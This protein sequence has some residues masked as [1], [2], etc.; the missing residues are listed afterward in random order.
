[1]WYYSMNN[2]PAGPVDGDTIRSLLQSGQI[3]ANTLVWQEGMAD[4]KRLGETAFAAPVPPPQSV[5]QYA[6]PTTQAPM[7]SN[8][9][10]AVA[11]GT[12]PPFVSPVKLSNIKTFYFLWLALFAVGTLSTLFF[13]FANQYSDAYTTLACIVSFFGIAAAV[14]IYIQVYNFWKILQDGYAKITP[15]KAVGFLFIPLF[16]LYWAF[17]AFFG[18]SNEFNTFIDRHFP[19]ISGRDVRRSTPIISMVYCV[20]FILNFFLSMANYVSSMA[21]ESSF[22]AG[23]STMTIVVAVFTVLWAVM[24]VL[25]FTDYYQTAKSILEN[26]R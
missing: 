16:N 11:A 7:Y 10:P 5:Q 24:T 8:Y 17:Q 15:G 21:G 6:Q 13:M 4:W 2:Q 1:M 23:D 25:A 18:L 22:Y 3:N 9:P 14:F 20:F 26:Q 19:A 12:P